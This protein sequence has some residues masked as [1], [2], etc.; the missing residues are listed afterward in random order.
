MTENEIAKEIVD[1]AF[2]VHRHLGPGLFEAVYHKVLAYELERRGFQVKSKQRMAICYEGLQVD[3]A[4]EADLIVN[5]AVS[6]ELKSV[7][8]LGA[9]HK[10]QL[11]TYLRLTGLRLGLL[12][13]FNVE[14]IRDGIVRVVNG[15]PDHS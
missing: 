15:L 8:L 3:D 10:K 1:A 2:K 12:I 7:E 6:I 9:I 5:D 4:F 14:L 11:T 13:N